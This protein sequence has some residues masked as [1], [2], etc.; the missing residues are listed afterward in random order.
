MWLIYWLA[1]SIYQDQNDALAYEYAKKALTIVDETVKKD[2]SNIRA[3]QQLAKSYST[4]GETAITIGKPTEAI[5]YLEKACRMQSEITQNTTK[6][7]RLKS[8]LAI[9]LT[10]LGEA[11]AKQAQYED[12]LANL[13]RAEKIYQDVIQSNPADRRSYRNLA[14]TYEE[15]GNTYRKLYEKKGRTDLRDLARTNYQAALDIYVSLDEKNELT[16]FDRKSLAE[17]KTTLAK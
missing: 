3:K 9:S 17:L 4:L 1:S 14:L 5:E 2:D 10:R 16:S 15:I 6:N 8:D 13:T 11:K 12:S 7:A